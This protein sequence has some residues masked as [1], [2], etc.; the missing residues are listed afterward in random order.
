M[1]RVL[2]CALAAACGSSVTAGN[3]IQVSSNKVSIDPAV[4]VTAGGTLAAPDAQ[5]LGGVAATGYLTTSDAEKFVTSTTGVAADAKLLGG[6]APS[7]YQLA[8]AAAADSAK[9]GGVA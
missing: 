8:G 5:K 1:N 6:V 7:A 4:V 9:L 2:V 3:G